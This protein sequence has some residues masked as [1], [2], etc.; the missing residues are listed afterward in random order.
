MSAAAKID[1]PFVGEDLD[2]KIKGFLAGRRP[3]RQVIR[4]IELLLHRSAT[5]QIHVWREAERLT[6]AADPDDERVALATAAVIA[7]HEQ[8]DNASN[9]TYARFYQQQTSPHPHPSPEQMRNWVGGI[10]AARRLAGLDP[11]ADLRSHRLLSSGIKYTDQEI[12][13]AVDLWAHETTG[14]LRQASYVDFART[15]RGKPIP[16]L[17]MPLRPDCCRRL[18]GWLAV[19]AKLGHAGRASTSVQRR[20]A[21]R[22]WTDDQITEL[23]KQAAVEHGQMLPGWRY[24]AFADRINRQAAEQ[25]RPRAAPHVHTIRKRFGT[26]LNAKAAAGLPRAVT[27]PAVTGVNRPS[28]SAELERSMIDAIFELGP[29]IT[30]N[31]YRNRRRRLSRQ[32]KMGGEAPPRVA[33]MDAIRRLADGGSFDDARDAVLDR[34]PELRDF[35]AAA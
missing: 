19:L 22:D 27:K 24:Q 3:S 16:R 13:A 34:H 28:D 30:H 14:T 10:P 32:A 12:L 29:A 4:L 18:G 31:G 15:E 25:G 1:E 8:H 35:E 6:P 17:R 11:A 20:D 23:L 2:E 26:W 33:N 7:C 9:K 21:Q 5:D